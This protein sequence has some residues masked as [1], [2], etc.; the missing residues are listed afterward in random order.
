M[1]SHATNVVMSFNDCINR[2]DLDG[3][4]SL[5]TDDHVFVDSANS[6]IGGK[7][8]CLEAWRQFCTAFPDYRNHFERVLSAG[9]DVIIIG[10]SVCSDARLAGP[11]LWSARIEGACIAEWRVYEDTS[12]NRA[13]LGL[14]D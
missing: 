10:R 1:T 5:M 2:R 4:S 12:V 11:A 3:L 9:S 14:D 7:A 13:L 6:T 8:L